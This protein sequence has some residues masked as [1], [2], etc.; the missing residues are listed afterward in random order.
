MDTCLPLLLRPSTGSR[1]DGQTDLKF[2]KIDVNLSCFFL[3]FQALTQ[4]VAFIVKAVKNSDV[5]EVKDGMKVSATS[6]QSPSIIVLH[7]KIFFIP[8][9]FRPKVR[10]TSWPIVDGDADGPP[11]AAAAAAQHREAPAPAKVPTVVDAVAKDTPTSS[12]SSSLTAAR[13]NPF[14]PEFVPTSVLLQQDGQQQQK[15]SV[16]NGEG[17]E[18][19]VEVLKIG[20]PHF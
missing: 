17:T 9:Q 12:S 2:L 3:L 19:W 8:P 14:V 16:P 13:L 11:A 6:S 4:D 10:P 18:T 15:A 5:V 1:Y 7:R 20:P